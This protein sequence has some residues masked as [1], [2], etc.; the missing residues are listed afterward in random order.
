LIVFSQE[1]DDGGINAAMKAMAN[2]Q[3]SN[4]TSS[5]GG[6]NFNNS[7]AAASAAMNN[8]DQKKDD[9]STNQGKTTTSL[10][11]RKAQF[12]QDEKQRQ[13]EIKSIRNE[14]ENLAVACKFSFLEIFL[15]LFHC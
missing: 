15:F 9:T 4:N 10:M 3:S 13:E 14:I 8:S 12:E 7:L 6:S 1:A 5:G 2:S 11:D